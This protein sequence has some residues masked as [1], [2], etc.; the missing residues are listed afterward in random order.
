MLQSAT[1]CSAVDALPHAPWKSSRARGDVANSNSITPHAWYS[2]VCDGSASTPLANARPRARAPRR[3]AASRACHVAP[4]RARRLAAIDHTRAAASD[5][6]DRASMQSHDCS[7][8]RFLGAARS[9]FLKRAARRAGG[10]AVA[11]SVARGRARARAGRRCRARAR[12]GPRTSAASSWL[13]QRHSRTPQA[14]RVAALLTLMR[15]ERLKASR[16]A[17]MFPRARAHW[18]IVRATRSDAGAT[19]R[20]KRGTTRRRAAPPRSSR[21]H[22]T[23]LAS[24]AAAAQRARVQLERVVRQP[25]TV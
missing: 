7:R 3:C 4:S 9:P 13:A 12:A 17:A 18:P 20:A 10:T 19:A 6:P 11:R 14:W 24:W 23:Q 2:A 15:S 22:A 25:A 5:E 16:G 21:L 1:L 8:Y